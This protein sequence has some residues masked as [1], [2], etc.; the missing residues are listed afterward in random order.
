MVT[1]ISGTAF[2]PDTNWTSYQRRYYRLRTGEIY[3]PPSDYSYSLHNGQVTITKYHGPTGAVTMPDSIEGL[4][5][6]SIGDGA[7]SY[8]GVSSV[9]IPSAITNIG[10]YAFAG[11]TNLNSVSFPDGI[12]SIGDFAFENLFRVNIPASVVTLGIGAIGGS[13]LQAI[14]VEPE[15]LVFSSDDG[16][17]LNK[18]RTVVL[19]F[20]G[21]VGGSYTLPLGIETVASHAFA[22]SSLGQVILPFGVRSI[23]SWAFAHCEALTNI[24]VPPTLNSISNNAFIS[25]V[26]LHE[27]S[28]PDS[29]TSIG[30]SAFALCKNLLTCKFPTNITQIDQA[31]FS[32]CLNLRTATFGKITRIGDFAFYLCPQLTSIYFEGDAPNYEPSTFEHTDRATIFRLPNTMGWGPTFAGRPTAVWDW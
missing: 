15:S 31:M 29:I 19:Q 3:V 6:T 10:S 21:S 20:P 2:V 11:C 7:F 4:P 8:H 22:G 27:I 23:G 18:A 16:V 24:V 26:E 28:L 13:R 12:L 1:L 5:V 30:D 14:E 9:A 25:C 17:L 32:N